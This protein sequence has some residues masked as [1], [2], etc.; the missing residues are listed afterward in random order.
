[1]NVGRK[2]G[3]QDGSSG[4]HSQSRHVRGMSRMIALRTSPAARCPTTDVLAISV[5]PVDGKV[6]DD[7]SSDVS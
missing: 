4:F 3:G 6:D 5:R 2:H 7:G 1:M